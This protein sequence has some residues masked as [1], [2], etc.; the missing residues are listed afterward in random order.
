MI[1]ITIT[2]KYYDANGLETLCLLHI[3]G[4]I[5]NIMQKGSGMNIYRQVRN[6]G[7]IN[8]D[9]KRIICLSN[10]QDAKTFHMGF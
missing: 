3:L 1:I 8:E 9:L 4:S 5:E 2:I 10:K 7:R 6:H